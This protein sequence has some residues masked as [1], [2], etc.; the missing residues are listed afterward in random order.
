M[1]NLD[2]QVV[3]GRMILRWIFREVGYRGMD[4]IELALD[5]NRWRAFVKAVMNFLTS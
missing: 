4:W 1:D 5:M 3:D 2:D